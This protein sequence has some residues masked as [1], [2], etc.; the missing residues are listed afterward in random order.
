M[1]FFSQLIHKRASKETHEFIRERN[2]QEDR[3]IA[4]TE[5]HCTVEW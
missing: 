5:K 1:I 3:L 4:Y 2:S